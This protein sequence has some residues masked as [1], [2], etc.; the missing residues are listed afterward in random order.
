[1]ASY[2]AA[3]AE[4]ELAGYLAGPHPVEKVLLDGGAVRMVADGAADLVVVERSSKPL[5]LMRLIGRVL[6]VNL[7][8][9]RVEGAFGARAGHDVLRMG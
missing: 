5:I 7:V 9:E 4:V 2:G 8:W 1:M 3:V 6:R